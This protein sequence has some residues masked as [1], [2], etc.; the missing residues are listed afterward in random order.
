MT[1]D[2]AGLLPHITEKQFLAQVLE[3][4]ALCH[5]R[6]YHSWISIR[7]AQGF[8]DLVMV[9]LSRILF[10]ELKSERGR[11]SPAQQEWLND[12]ALTGKVEVEIWRPSNWETL[13]EVLR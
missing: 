3:L 11:V 5:W 2:V 9:R 4:A 8:P 12:L 7:S 6:A 13:V 1:R 10:V